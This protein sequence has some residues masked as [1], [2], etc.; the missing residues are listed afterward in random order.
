MALFFFTGL[1]FGQS[2]DYTIPAIECMGVE[3]DGSQ[4]LRVWALGRNK[5]DAIE[6]AKKNAVREVIFKGIRNGSS[7][8]N[9]RPLMYE[10]NGEEKYQYY[11]NTFFKD[12]GEYLKYVSME[13]RRAFT[14]RKIKTTNQVKCGLTVRV[15]RPELLQRLIEDK[16]IKP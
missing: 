16:I 3:G 15:L 11:F 8:C 9:I 4:T 6:Q 12:G 2:D 14:T 1:M 7:E 13:D 5:T 10:V